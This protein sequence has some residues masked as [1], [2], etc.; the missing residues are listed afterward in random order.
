M[1]NQKKD[2]SNFESNNENHYNS[3]NFSQSSYEHVNNQN[4]NNQLQQN[5]TDSSYNEHI[6]E[7]RSEQNFQSPFNQPNP[8]YSAHFQENP[9]NNQL[10]NQNRIVDIQMK[11][12]VAG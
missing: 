2:Q 11:E 6:E 4:E 8:Y 1:D 7:I 10:P 3:T 9:N 12:K 5:H